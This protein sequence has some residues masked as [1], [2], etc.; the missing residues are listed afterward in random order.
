MP[1][2]RHLFPETCSFSL[3]LLAFYQV[4]SHFMCLFMT[5]LQGSCFKA[6]REENIE[7]LVIELVLTRRLKAN[8]IYK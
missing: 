4:C 6:T 8:K 7:L 3:S 5:I 1:S 2:T